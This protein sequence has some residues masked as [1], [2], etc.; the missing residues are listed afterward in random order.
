MSSS[1]ECTEE[2][3]ESG[4][5]AGDRR[6]E[7]LQALLEALPDAVC[8]FDPEDGTLVAWNDRLEAVTGRDAG[9]LADLSVPDLVEPAGDQA[10][11]D[12]IAGVVDGDGGRPFRAAVVTDDG[13]R[14]PHE[15]VASSLEG[16]AGD[17]LVVASGRDVGGRVADR[18][19]LEAENERLEEFA[20][21]V[22]HDLRTP[23]AVA[24][25]YLQTALDDYEDERLEKAADALDRMD[26]LV[27]GVLRLATEGRTVG[28]PEPVALGRAASAA[29]DGVPT[30]GA[31]LALAGDLPVVDADP[32]RLVRV[33]ENLFRNAVEHA[34]TTPTV[35]V[36]ATDGGFY[37]ADD[38]P[39]VPEADRDRLFEPGHSG[40]GATTGV[41]L[42]IVR[43]LATA[44]DWQVDVA[45]SETGGARFEFTGVSSA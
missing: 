20:E 5:P 3:V 7:H 13:E 21:V 26:A 43:K 36:G 11:E 45:E 9:E 8:A 2:C 34:G 42:G 22:S 39:G 6:D 44:H 35:E 10:V 31:S 41:G 24:T 4:L 23:M 19:A 16:A 40:D 15:F 1:E 38:G 32:D 33:F 37:V 14:R 17:D 30:E 29:W 27:D 12:A 25:G 18:R 28:A